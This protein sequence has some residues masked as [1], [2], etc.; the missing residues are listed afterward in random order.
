M[1][2][3]FRRPHRKP[4][5]APPLERPRV[6]VN[7]PV[8]LTDSDDPAVATAAAELGNW[9]VE[10]RAAERALA[11]AIADEHDVRAVLVTTDNPNALRDVFEGARPRGVPV[12]VGCRDDVAR[13]RAVELRADEWYRMP[14]DAEEIAARI[15]SAISRVSAAQG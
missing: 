12:V 5:P 9:R 7:T 14:A 2:R 15:R 6:R 11:A 1:P 8:L 10:V 3:F 13:R 4:P